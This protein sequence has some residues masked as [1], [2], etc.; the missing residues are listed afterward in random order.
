VRARLTA[1]AAERA[2]TITSAIA[3]RTGIEML[4]Q[5]VPDNP[6]KAA[7]AGDYLA[8]MFFALVFGIGLTPRPAR[9]RAG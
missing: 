3:P 2:A 8:L 7:S 1:G 4:V 9:A 5:I 6:V